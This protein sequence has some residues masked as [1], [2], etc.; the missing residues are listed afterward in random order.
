LK[1]EQNVLVVGIPFG[2]CQYLSSERE[3]DVKIEI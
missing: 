2:I 1:L 3:Q